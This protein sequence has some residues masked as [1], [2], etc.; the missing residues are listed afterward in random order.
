MTQ[1]DLFARERRYAYVDCRDEKGNAWCH[2]VSD[3]EETI[4][5]IE[6]ELPGVKCEVRE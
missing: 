2:R 4:R 6:A 5:F 3:P 1:L